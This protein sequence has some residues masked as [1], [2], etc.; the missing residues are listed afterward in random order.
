MQY[1]FYQDKAVIE[2]TPLKIKVKQ[3]RKRT[4]KNRANK[5][6]NKEYKK[7]QK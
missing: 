3:N 7:K 1:F 4:A 5:T 6:L 2:R